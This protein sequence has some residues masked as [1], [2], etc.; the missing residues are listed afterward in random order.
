[1]PVLSETEIQIKLRGLLDKL[2]PNQAE[3]LRVRQLCDSDAEAA[4]KVGIA[5]TTVSRW[6]KD[7]EFMTAYTI[8]TQMLGAKKELVVADQNKQAIVK[9]QMATLMHTLPDIV[10]KLL[11]IALNG[12]SEEMKVR[13]MK[14]IFDTVGMGPQAEL[15]LNKQ[16][17]SFLQ[18]AELLV[19]QAQ[20]ELAKRGA[21]DSAD[22]DLETLIREGATLAAEATDTKAIAEEMVEEDLEDL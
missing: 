17:K 19:P 12:K 9:A 4:K 7:A 16:T 5:T 11:D 15:P 13:A 21:I 20:H 14:L 10:Q 22:K 1:M 2:S 18:V 8:T 3:Y 6:K